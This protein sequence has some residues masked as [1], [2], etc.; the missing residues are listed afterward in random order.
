MKFLLAALLGLACVSATA[1]TRIA[2]VTAKQSAPLEAQISVTIERPTPLDMMCDSTVD[3][4]DGTPPKALNFGMGDKHA[5]TLQHKYAKAGTYKVT[6]KGTGRCEGAREAS[7]TVQAGA[8]EKNAS[9]A[10]A[11]C[12][13]GWTLLADS[14]KGNRYACAANPPSRPIKC[15]GGAKYFAESGKIGCR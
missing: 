5:K 11:R 12:P 1:A 4:G 15:E 2:G 8:G 14:H 3:M 6:V 10:A 9:A 13:A 7:V